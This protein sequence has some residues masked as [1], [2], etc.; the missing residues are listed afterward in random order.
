MVDSYYSVTVVAVPL[1]TDLKRFWA[2]IV[3]RAEGCVVLLSV[4][5]ASTPTTNNATTG[6]TSIRS[7]EELG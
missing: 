4:A 1:T 7:V 5:N 2:F 6:T 3:Q